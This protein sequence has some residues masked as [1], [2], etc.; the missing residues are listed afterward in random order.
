MADIYGIAVSLARGNPDSVAAD[1]EAALAPE[2]DLE[3]MLTL[4]TRRPEVVGAGVAP[5]VDDFAALESAGSQEA[6]QAVLDEVVAG[7]GA[8]TIAG[9]FCNVAATVLQSYGAV[10][11]A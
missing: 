9:P 10:M 6:A 8:G 11:E 5:L 1:V 2:V 7:V 4:A 3:A